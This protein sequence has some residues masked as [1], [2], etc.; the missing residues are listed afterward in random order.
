MME[1][2]GGLSKNR[3]R[4]DAPAATLHMAV[5]EVGDWLKTKAR[6]YIASE[7]SAWCY[8][9]ALQPYTRS[10]VRGKEHK[11]YPLHLLRSLTIDHPN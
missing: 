4:S 3:D 1:P 9:R 6:Q 11:I 2:K 7:F 5:S 10:L 8:E